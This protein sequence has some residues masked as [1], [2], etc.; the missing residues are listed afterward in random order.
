MQIMSQFLTFALSKDAIFK[1]I[2]LFTSYLAGK[3]AADRDEYDKV[4]VVS[5]DRP[6]IEVM[7][8]DA[9][10][11]MASAL[12]G[13]VTNFS[14]EGDVMQLTLLNPV[15]GLDPADYGEILREVDCGLLLKIMESY[16]VSAVINRWLEIAGYQFGV[17]AKEA[18][19]HCERVM[20]RKMAELDSRLTPPVPSA[21]KRI[22]KARSRRLPPI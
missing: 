18:R 15:Y 1:Q 10:A 16:V 20:N 12:G 21:T 13:R 11:E 14:I 22:V 2:S 8:E 9:A 7:T 3:R 19:V 5:L 4:A 17:G 6:L